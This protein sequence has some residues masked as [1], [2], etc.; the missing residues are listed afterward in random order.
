MGGKREIRKEEHERRDTPVTEYAWEE[1]EK[2][3]EK[4]EWNL[5]PGSAFLW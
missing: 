1:M 5:G 4:S 2:A 3:E